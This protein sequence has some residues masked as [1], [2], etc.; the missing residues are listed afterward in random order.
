[1]PVLIL[2]VLLALLGLTGT[3]WAWWANNTAQKKKAIE[4]EDKKID[5]VT[6]ADDTIVE[7]D[8]LR[9]EPPSNRP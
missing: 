1:M 6:N 5:S 7:L 8:R 2:Q 4:D 9:N 3:I